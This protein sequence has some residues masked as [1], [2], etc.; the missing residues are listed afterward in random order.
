MQLSGSSRAL[1]EEI[2]HTSDWVSEKLKEALKLET[3]LSTDHLKPQDQIMTL[4]M[5]VW[6]I[7]YIYM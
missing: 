4:N 5:K 6:H 7:I 2:A 3:K 1:Q